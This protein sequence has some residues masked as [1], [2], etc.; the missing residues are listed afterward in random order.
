M[1]RLL[2]V[3]TVAL[4]GVG[5]W[6]ASAHYSLEVHRTA[7]GAF[8][9]VRI[10]PRAAKIA[11]TTETPLDQPPPAPLK[12]TIRIATFNLDG[13]D[14][15]R[16]AN[17]KVSEG[18]VRIL[19]RFDV[20]ALQNISATNGGVLMRLKDLINATGRSY[21]FAAT[22]PR[23]DVK[24]PTAHAIDNAFLFDAATVEVDHSALYSVEAPPGTFR[25]QPLVAEFRVRGP[26]AK[27]AF[28]FALVNVLIDPPG[29]AQD[30][31][32]LADVFR[33][34]VK[35][36]RGEDDFIMLGDFEADPEHF[37]RLGNVPGMTEAITDAPTTLRGT[38]LVDNIVF[39]HRAT[40]EYTGRS[41]VLDMVRELDLTPHEALEISS[42]LPV[43][44]EFSSY[45]NGQAS[46]VN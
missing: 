42:H 18:L 13:L 45:E 40:V 27:E 25:V 38:R 32:V 12:Q 21:D 46:H 1:A 15:S 10:V 22:P 26:A 20:V 17:P 37:E 39:D 16:L 5:G 4:L 36:S 41:G 23:D 3:T 7:E 14:D 2:L 34:A 9:Y 19:S 29:G 33:A 35:N 24:G 30:M 44:A 31:S 28:T 43:W 6:Y 8:Q 11:T